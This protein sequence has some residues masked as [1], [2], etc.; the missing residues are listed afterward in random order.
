MPLLLKTKIDKSKIHG[1]GLIAD[2][3][4]PT[5]TVVW[6]HCPIIDGWI[7]E[8][9][10]EQ[11]GYGVFSE[12]VDHFLCYDTEKKAYIRAAD[13]VNWMNHSDVSNLDSPTKYIHVSKR[14]ILKGE[15]LTINYNQICD[16]E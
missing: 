5:N 3:D 1:L 15:E 10:I 2:Q 14:N 11:L 4:I 7:R 8:S 6:K 12:H 13:N 9:D 16:L